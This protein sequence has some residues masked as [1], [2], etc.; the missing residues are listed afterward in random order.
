MGIVLF[1]CLV[2]VNLM[3]N[4]TGSSG[5]FSFMLSLWGLWLSLLSTMGIV[6]RFAGMVAVGLINRFDKQWQ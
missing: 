4:G 2:W 1:L 3:N 5:S 6:G